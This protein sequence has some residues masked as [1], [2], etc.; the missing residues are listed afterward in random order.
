MFEVRTE[1]PDGDVTVV[2]VSGEVDMTVSPRFERSLL[3]AAS[4]PGR[5]V[6][7]DLARLDFLDSSGV[8]ALIKGYHAS[9][10][11]GG[12]LTVRGATGGVARVLYITGVAEVL[13][14]AVA[15]QAGDLPGG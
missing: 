12:S 6:V 7:V 8:H 14:M 1:A 5:H 10:A 4:R 2:R 9:N 15:D 3:D 11:A 13:G